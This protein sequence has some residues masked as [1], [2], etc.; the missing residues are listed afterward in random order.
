MSPQAPLSAANPFSQLS[1]LF[2]KAKASLLW[3]SS[4]SVHHPPTPTTTL[5]PSLSCGWIFQFTDLPA[6]AEACNRSS[7]SS[8]L[9]SLG[10]FRGISAMFLSLAHGHRYF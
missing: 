10:R 8:A 1:T 9:V 6:D 7:K 5:P 3:S 2:L 4:S